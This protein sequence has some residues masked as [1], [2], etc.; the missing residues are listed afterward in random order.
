MNSF[1]SPSSIV[2]PEELTPT[3]IQ[4]VERQCELQH[5]TSPEQRLGFAKAYAAAK[6]LA[7]NEAKLEALNA[8]LLHELILEWAALIESRNQKG[9]RRVVVR[10]ANGTTALA[11]E[12]VGRAM[13]QY[14]EL[15][16]GKNFM[17]EEAYREFEL[18]HPLE[19]GNGRLGDLLWKIA[20]TR[21]TGA[22]PESLPPDIFGAHAST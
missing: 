9:F 12:L 1:E 20:V 4:L 17:P 5:A 21:E 16:A 14:V 7:Q 13:Q 22:W 10:F 3:D 15:Y 18:I 19:D 6:Q 11:P 8:E 2:F